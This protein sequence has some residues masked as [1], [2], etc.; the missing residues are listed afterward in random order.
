MR[1]LVVRRAAHG[2]RA[3]ASRDTLVQGASEGAGRV[4]VELG[5]DHRVGVRHDV[6]LRVG[7]TERLDGCGRDVGD[8][9]VRALVDRV[10]DQVAADLADAGDADPPSGQARRP[11]QVLRRRPHPL[12]DAEGG[13]HAGVAGPSAGL[14]PPGDEVTLPR[15]DVHVV[16]VRA[17]VGSR[18]VATGER[19]D[20][21]SVRAQQRLGLVRGWVADDH[22]LAAAVVEPGERVL[23]GHPLAQGEDVGQGFGLGRVRVEARAAERGPQGR[24]VQGDDRAQP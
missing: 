21:P 10:A 9:D 12:V 20:E 18:D 5:A 4:Q 7:G 24:G 11:P 2:G 22:G 13:E 23:V 17:Y 19:L 15:D 1:E 3:Q 6:H 16:H 14:A 8:D